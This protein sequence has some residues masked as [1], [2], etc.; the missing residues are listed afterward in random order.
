[1][2]EQ[3]NTLLDSINYPEDL[4]KL[5]E[6]QLKQVSDELREFLITSV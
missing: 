5:P 1:M 4:R 2:K 6:T 3:H